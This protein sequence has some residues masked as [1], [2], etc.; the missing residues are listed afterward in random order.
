MQVNYKKAII[1]SSLKVSFSNNLNELWN[2]AWGILPRVKRQCS[3][4]SSRKRLLLL[5]LQKISREIWPSSLYFPFLNRAESKG[6]MC[7]KARFCQ[8]ELNLTSMWMI[9]KDRWVR[10]MKSPFGSGLKQVVSQKESV[11]KVFLAAE[12]R[13]ERDVL[14]ISTWVLA[15]EAS[16]CLSG[17]SILSEL[18][19]LFHC[20]MRR[21]EG[22][23]FCDWLLFWKG[24]K[25]TF[26]FLSIGAKSP[27]A[28]WRTFQI[29][30]TK[31]CLFRADIGLFTSFYLPTHGKPVSFIC[32]P[33][34][35]CLCNIW[36]EH[37]P[38]EEALFLSPSASSKGM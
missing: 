20:T 38:G 34:T 17:V 31:T 25:I 14:A 26:H 3:C 16:Y 27:V 18:Q 12:W 8:T 4:L 36:L 13:G 22:L 37:L 2:R 29:R 28:V 21:A 11:Y 32:Q 24:K 6:T 10:F 33:I 15:D 30:L 7:L 5:I 19:K 1:K 35:A 9:K 23:G